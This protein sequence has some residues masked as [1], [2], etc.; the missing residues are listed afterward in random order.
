MNMKIGYFITHFPY[1]SRLDDNKYPKQYKHGGSEVAAYHLAINM[2]HRENDVSVFTTSVD[3]KDFIEKYKNITVYRYGTKFQVLNRSISFSMLFKPLKHGLDIVHLHTS[4]SPIDLSSALLYAKKK[5]KTL[6]LTYH[7]DVN[8]TLNKFS[9]KLAAYFYDKLIGKLLSSAN[10]IISPSQY[11]IEESRFLKKYKNKIIIIPNGINVEK[12]DISYSKE[13]CR[14]KL[15]LLPDENIILF[16]GALHPHKG[17]DVLIKAMPKIIK[18]VQKVK[19]IFVG[20]GAMRGEL[21]TLSKKLG[22]DNHIRFTGFV[23]E[24]L[25]LLY[26]KSADIFCLPSVMTTEV[27]PIVFLE[28]SASCI[29]MVVSNLDTFKCIIEEGYNGLFTKRG[30][31][32]NLADAI[33][34][35]LENGDV[36]KKMGKNARKK[37]GDYSWERIAEETEKVYMEV[38][39]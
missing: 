16:V 27:F 23:E 31:E 18:E 19:L 6:I 11:Y 17:P 34:Y 13:E 39:R 37:V 12:F 25:K 26:Y 3:S 30:D 9:Y 32:K 33:I 4:A 21:E 24:T 29:P 1:Q 38:L 14:V 10:V 5:E 20:R 28:A 35:L 8:V 15:G 7:G 36:R 2:A 22:I